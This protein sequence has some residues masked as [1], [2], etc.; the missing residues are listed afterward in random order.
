MLGLIASVG[1]G[2]VRVHRRPRVAILSTGNELSRPGEELREGAVRDSNSVVLGALARSWG[3]EVRMLG[4]ARDTAGELT[5]KLK[6]AADV[7]LIVT[8]G[9]VS[10]GDFDLVK[11]IL[12]AHGQ[13]DI[14]QVR[15]K[16]GKPLAFG[17][18]EGK[19]LL[20]L[21]GNPV[22]AAVSFIVFG[23]PAIRRML[24]DTDIGH[25]LVEVVVEHAVENRGQR[26]HFARVQLRRGPHGTIVARGAGEQGAGIL[27]SLAA[28]DAL[29]VVP[30]TTE[31][32][33]AG[34]RMQAILVDWARQE[35]WL[36]C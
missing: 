1:V 35:N 31:L 25:R 9:G 3:S 16:P 18:L 36:T 28:A 22:A 20:G 4:I 7:D 14:W 19:P 15:M 26:R 29:L 6:S 11:N 23:Q 24:G 32:A 17:L 12:R 21:P 5:E 30:E 27:S 33:P 34:T 10:V 13:V 2:N 8:S